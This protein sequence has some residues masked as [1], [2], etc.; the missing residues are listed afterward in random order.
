[1]NMKARC[2]AALCI[3]AAAAF[4]EDKAATFTYEN[5]LTPIADPQPILADHPEWVQPVEEAA[6]YEAPILVN[7]TGGTIEVRAWRF[8]YNARGIIEM[9]NLLR[10]DQTAIIVV[11]PWG[12]DDGQGWRTPE[13]A[14]VA[15]FCTPIKNDLS[16]KHIVEVLNP[17]LKAYRDKVAFVL[18]SQPGNEDAIR[19][20]LY[21]SVRG[22]PT[23]KQYAQGQKELAEKLNSF[24][25]NAGPLPGTIEL[26][27]QAP[28]VDYFKA[29]PGLDSSAHYDGEGFWDLPIPV[30]KNIEVDPND[31]LIYD[32]EGY[33]VLKKFLKDNGVRHV[34]LTGYCTD[35]CFKSTCAGYEN[36][37]QDFDVFLVG[38]ATLATFPSNST[39]AYATNAALSYAALDQ[40]VTQISW[41]K[42]TGKKKTKGR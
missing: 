13:P 1:M 19:R 24:N 32:K 25:Y 4:A 3:L 7:D 14:G 40:L 41:I 29:F 26:G 16:H 34:L 30:V 15:D 31:V 18:Y 28:V 17:F 10:G 5:K 21:R 39:P 35:M 27:T 23:K 22:K 36:L 9:P 11:H 20:K 2:A 33:D 42:Y 38:D 37:S 6:R 8:S 12:I